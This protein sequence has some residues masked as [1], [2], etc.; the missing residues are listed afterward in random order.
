MSVYTIDN[1]PTLLKRRDVV[2]FKVGEEKFKY[3]V[4]SSYLENEGSGNNCALFEALGLKTV[5]SRSDFCTKAYGYG[6]GS[7]DWPEYDDYAAATR[8]VNAVFD[9]IAGKATTKAT[10]I[11]QITLFEAPDG[12]RFN[13]RAEAE[14]HSTEQSLSEWLIKDCGF[15]GNSAADLALLIVRHWDVKRKA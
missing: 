11:K 4:F 13:T 7:G 10:S 9:R 12:A 8:C 14:R 3:T 1:R 2:K 15:S 6:A 5:A